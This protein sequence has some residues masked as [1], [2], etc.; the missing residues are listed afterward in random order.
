MGSESPTCPLADVVAA[1]YKGSWR[2]GPLRLWATE[3][4]HFRRMP[5]AAGVFISACIV[6]LGPTALPV[7]SDPP[8]T[9]WEFPVSGH[10]VV[11]VSSFLSCRRG[12]IFG[13]VFWSEK[14]KNKQT[15]QIKFYVSRC[16]RHLDSSGSD[17]SGLFSWECDRKVTHTQN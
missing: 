12:S 2:E 17:H 11:V 3:D 4:K 7:T 10:W 9:G 13:I 5:I 6:G 1:G 15:K 16:V 14:K 8:T